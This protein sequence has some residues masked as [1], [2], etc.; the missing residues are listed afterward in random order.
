VP[1]IANWSPT[2]GATWDSDDSD[3]CPGSGSA[4]VAYQVPNFGSFDQ[5]IAAT[6]GTRYNFG[7]R[8]KQ[9]QSQS[10]ACDLWFFAGPT[11]SD[12]ILVGGDL[13]LAGAESAVTSWLKLSGSIT[14]PAGTGSANVHCQNQ[15]GG[16]GNIDQIHVSTTN[17]SY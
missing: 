9:T 4:E 15:G 2:T 12:N 3:G 5:C 16:S 8:Y 1:G 11:C 13:L 14:A 17:N 7:F 10:V 6:A